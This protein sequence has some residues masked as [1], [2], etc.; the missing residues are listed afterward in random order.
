[1]QWLR[2]GL[3]LIKHSSEIEALA[4]RVKDSDGVMFV[5]ALV[6]LGAPYWRPEA[7]G[8]LTGIERSTTQAH[9]ARA[10][11][12][13]I[14]YLQSDIAHAMEKDSRKKL[15]I[16]KVD[17]GASNNNLLMQFQADILGTKLVRPKMVETTALG[18]AFL[19]GLAVGM[20][21]SE[22]QIRRSWKKDR[23]FTPK[24]KAADRK[25]LLAK[26]QGV[27]TRA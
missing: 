5:P 4:R 26:W 13:G 21:K 17:G 2:D 10:V 15:K 24:M 14:A 19:A 8:L 7:R 12:E 25:A 23:E 1:M 16:L 22:D 6:G 11:L 3:Q 27:V 9:I 18:A 20:W